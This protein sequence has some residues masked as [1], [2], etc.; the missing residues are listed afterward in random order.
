MTQ[1][2]A[3]G[4]AENDP[5]YGDDAWTNSFGS[6]TFTQ[7]VQAI[8]GRYVGTVSDDDSKTSNYLL[9]ND[10]GFTIPGG[11][12]IRGIVVEVYRRNESGSPAT[13][14]DNVISLVVGGVVVGDNKADPTYWPSDFSFHNASYGDSIDTWGNSLTLSD[15]N[16]S[17]FGLVIATEYSGVIT[18][19]AH[20][21]A[22][23][24]YA[25][26]TV[27]H[28]TP[29]TYSDT[30]SGGA[31]AGGSATV[32]C[33]YN[34]TVS[35]GAL[36]GGTAP[37]I[38]SI[39]GLGGAIIGGTAS[40]AAPFIPAISGGALIGG[41][42]A[43]DFTYNP[44]ASGG[45]RIGGV[46]NS[47]QTRY[48]TAEAD[49][50]VE[51]GGVYGGGLG[52]VRVSGTGG[53]EIAGEVI[54]NFGFNLFRTFKWNTRAF[55][56]S[57]KTFLWNTGQLPAYYYRVVSKPVDDNE[58]LPKEPCCQR[59]IIT[60]HARTLSELCEKLSRR[61]FV[62]TIETVHR[63]GKP[64]N[65]NF[66]E[67]SEPF[68][69]CNDMTPIEVC[70]IP[71]CADFCV[72]A[73]VAQQ[74][75]YFISVQV[76]AFFEVVADG[77]IF[78]SGVADAALEGFVPNFP[79][80]ASGSITVGGE[81]TYISSGYV[82]YPD[83]AE[84]IT[85]GDAVVLSSSYHYVGGEASYSVFDKGAS[86]DEIDNNGE[87]WA[88][89][90]R[91][92]NDDGLVSQ[93]DISF[94]KTSQFLVI[95]GFDFSIPSDAEIISIVASV[96][97]FATTTG[98]RDDAVY[99]VLGDE[100]ISDNVAASGDWPLISTDRTYNN[101]RNQALPEYL[102]PFD[103]DDLNDTEFGFAIAVNNEASPQ[104][105]AI[106]KIDYVE[107]TVVYREV[108][109]QII[110]VEGSASVVSTSYSYVGSGP[111]LMSGNV[112]PSLNGVFDITGNSTSGAGIITGGSHGLS[113]SYECSGE[114]VIGG[115]ADT[116]CSVMTEVPLGGAVC[117]GAAKVTPYFEVGIGGAVAG[118]ST[119]DRVVYALPQASVA[120][121]TGSG[122]AQPITFSQFSYTPSGSVLIDGEASFVSS[123]YTW[124][125]DGL[126]ISVGGEA[127]VSGFQTISQTI[128]FDTEVFDIQIQFPEDED[129]E[130][131]DAPTGS[132]NKC[133]CE[134]LPLLIRMSHNM[135]Q[136]NVFTQ[137]VSQNNLTIPRVVPLLYNESN[138]S[139]Q[140]NL[141]FTG[142]SP[143]SNS[144]ETWS[145]VFE[146]QC[147]DEVG[148]INIGSNIW[149]FAFLML[150]K[151]LSTSESFDTR[152]IVGIV[153]DSTC[154]T[155]DL[156]F[157]ISYDT[158]ID[159]A[160]VSPAS[161]IYQ[162]RMY[163][164]IGLFRNRFW[165]ENPE[166][167][168]NLTETEVPQPIRRLNIDS[169]LSHLEN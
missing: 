121:V 117:G 24:E 130:T 47:S 60:L 87:E 64:A 59:F 18:G 48:A 72:D 10:F 122:S 145:I 124:I 127:G 67:S 93:S 88:L 116:K 120:G 142:V 131:F 150:R 13:C 108:A 75:G 84:I 63:F 55:V 111:I 158:Q 119:T 96:K 147:T 46:G 71:A 151:N 35:G 79:H 106:A 168:I 115:L 91:A 68:D 45:A 152:F 54:T 146:L 102:G 138:D 21:S 103:P 52:S 163:D 165:D 90:E 77:E 50:G 51:I 53:V 62:G 85:G 17:D 92:L 128:G 161:V 70:N 140:A 156:K 32:S 144:A 113:L 1:T 8:D 83:G 153:P 31:R 41:I 101:W 99:L 78:M 154:S 66:D 132:L 80:E 148:G 43:I 104:I 125:S 16:A 134:T 118:S 4:H 28:G 20:G 107:M 166:L 141:H 9:M 112:V 23:V 97:R 39:F 58:C 37:F 136:N 159:S 7:V 22:F 25:Q 105:S 3:C 76:N 123:G 69:G 109:H 34:P 38:A 57:E 129:V 40:L 126:S 42:P 98:V 135:F 143:A 114:V 82:Y 56:R 160:I 86:V 5:S 11:D 29:Q 19:S 139:W 164:N 81:A 26:I 36:I 15:V 73:D 155:G 100:F 162:V 89:P 95:R 12:S 133:N 30:G 61:N 33:L 65:L 137:F 110:R 44:V 169:Y 94:G 74:V 14:R 2:R 49:G 157:N 167:L 27:Y 149:K 6:F